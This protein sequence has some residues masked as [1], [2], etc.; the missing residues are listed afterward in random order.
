MQIPQIPKRLFPLYIDLGPGFA[1]IVIC[2]HPIAQAA[3]ADQHQNP[4]LDRFV[5]ARS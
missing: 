4:K 3:Q 5:T 1:A 2:G